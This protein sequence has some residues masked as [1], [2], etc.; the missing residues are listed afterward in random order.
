[1]DSSPKVRNYSVLLNS[2]ELK[3]ELSWNNDRIESTLSLLL[4]EGMAWIDAVDNSFWFPG[5]VQK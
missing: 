2:D 1:M 5:L 4:Q 3:K